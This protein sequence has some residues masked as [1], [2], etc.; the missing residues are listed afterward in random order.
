MEKSQ[1]L[2]RAGRQGQIWGC[3]ESCGNDSLGKTWESGTSGN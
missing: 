3:S 1:G 2:G